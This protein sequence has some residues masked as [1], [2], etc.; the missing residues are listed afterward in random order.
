M[1]I[2][3]KYKLIEKIM[4]TE[5]DLLLSQVKAI[6]DEGE[7]DLWEELGPELKESIKRGLSESQQGKGRPHEEVMAEIRKKYQ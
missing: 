3:T 1:D 6:L 7:K 4:Q 5:N 2:Q